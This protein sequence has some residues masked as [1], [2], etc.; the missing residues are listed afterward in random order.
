MLHKATSHQSW[1]HNPIDPHL[2]GLSAQTH[3]Y[4]MLSFKDHTIVKEILGEGKSFHI[5]YLCFSL[6]T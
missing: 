3:F 1:I 4:L 2:N 6:P 5:M